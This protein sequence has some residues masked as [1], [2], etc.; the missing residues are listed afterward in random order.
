MLLS[1]IP[2]VDGKMSYVYDRHVFH[3]VVD[4]GVTY[5]CMADA[6]SRRRARSAA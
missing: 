6:E 5:L 4:S 1:K 2:P 3:Y